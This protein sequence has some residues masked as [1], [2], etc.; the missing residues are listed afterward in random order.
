MTVDLNLVPFGL[1]SADGTLV[2]VADVPRGA[3]CG[4]ICPSCKTPLIAR[5]GEDKG[6]HFAHA[7]R[8][9]YE[10]TQNECEFSFYVSVRLMA[11]QII[12]S[13]LEIGLP[14]YKDCISEYDART[15]RSVS[16]CFTVT[17]AR[18][19][20][21]S[22]TEVEQSLSGIPVDVIGQ[23][24]DF[25]FVIYFTHPCRDIPVEITRP[26][27]THCGVVAV[28]LTGLPVKFRGARTSKVSYQSVLLE[29]LSNDMAS[30]RWIFHPRHERLRKQAQEKLAA[31]VSRLKPSSPN[32]YRRTLSVSTS[33]INIPSNPDP[34]TNEKRL[35]VFECVMC[36]SEWQ[37]WEPGLS[38]CPK[39]NTY[40]YRRRKEYV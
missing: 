12:G 4:C 38:E 31:T 18:R 27:D 23:V 21:L 16:E 11:R 22:N 1:N 33:K 35:A 7:S 6:W 10:N 39:C 26:I 32:T 3:K 13:E 25:R 15:G 17:P 5:Q 14:E 2:D 37:D 24:G 20:R 30:K 28:S 36:H 40:L 34:I 9:V 19:I 8:H 29:Y